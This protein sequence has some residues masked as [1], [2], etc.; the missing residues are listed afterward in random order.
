VPLRPRSIPGLD[1]PNVYPA[2]EAL[3]NLCD[4][5]EKVVVAGGGMVGVETA[6]HL[7][8]MGKQVTVIEMAEHM[9][10]I[11]GFVMND[12]L[13]KKQMSESHIDFRPG[14]KLLSVEGGIHGNTLQVEHGDSQETLSCDTLLMALGFAPTAQRAQEDY[15]AIC[16]VVC[17]GDSLATKKII[18]AVHEAYEAV[19]SL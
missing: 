5:G 10:P 17:I 19:R 12:E 6:L 1:G 18:N 14:T 9:L 15:G 2:T 3:R 16:D 4:V 7:D 11:P 8:R 13:L